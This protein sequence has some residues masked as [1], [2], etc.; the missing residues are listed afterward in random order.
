MSVPFD[1]YLKK[2]LQDPEIA[3]EWKRTRLARDLANW[4]TGLRAARGLSQH[5][6]AYLL[7]VDEYDVFF[8]EDGEDLPSLELLKHIVDT[9]KEP[10]AIMF[11]P[12]EAT[13]V[14]PPKPE[15]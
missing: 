14:L 5:G 7:G 3:A 1:A 4:F 12:G 10:I 6:M 13:I 15:S 9:L 8:C 11:T 2:A